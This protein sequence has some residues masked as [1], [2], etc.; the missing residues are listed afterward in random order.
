VFVERPVLPLK[1]GSSRKIITPRVGIA[2]GGNARADNYSTGIMQDLYVRALWAENDGTGA[3]IFSIDAL[4]LWD[5]DARRL[6]EAAGR[7]LGI[8]SSNVMVTCTHTHSGP[9]TLRVLCITDAKERSDTA[10]LQPW[11]NRLVEQACAAAE[12]ARDRAVPASLKLRF[13]ENEAVPNNR[14]LRMKTGETCMNWTLPPAA[15]V[16]KPLGPIDPQV[17]VA[18]FEGPNG[19][20]GGIVHFACHPAILAGLNMEISGDYCGLAMEQLEQALCDDGESSFLFLNGALGN[21]NHIDYRKPNHERGASEVQR[22]ATSLSAAVL[23][24]LNLP[25]DNVSRNEQVTV[26]FQDMLLPFRELDPKEVEEAREVIARYD[27]RSLS[28]ADGV[29]PELNARRIFRLQEA[30]HT[31]NYPGPFATLRDGK[32][33]TPLQVIRIGDLVLSSSPAEM[34]VEF[35]LELKQRMNSRAALL[36]CLAN[37]YVGYVP[38]PEAFEQGGYEPSTGPGFLRPEAGNQIITA[39]IEMETNAHGK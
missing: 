34:F 22:C 13:A 29:P 14:R 18:S 17:T 32:V 2:L 4:G 28:L 1:V 7:R 10:Q 19:V 3:C 23:G 12:S 8:P 5:A 27:G 11:L 26:L 31:G 33:V 36:V 9:D 25:S 35:G 21:I 30:Q 15:D 39:L 37:G 38:T 24:A 20:V 6:R 16:D